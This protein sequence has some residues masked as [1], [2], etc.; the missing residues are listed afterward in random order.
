MIIVCLLGLFFI[1]LASSNIWYQ[2]GYNAGKEDALREK[3]YEE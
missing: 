2:Q 1:F 3:N